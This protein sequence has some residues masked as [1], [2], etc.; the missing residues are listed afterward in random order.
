MSGSNFDSNP[1]LT[2]TL[3][4]EEDIIDV[5]IDIHPGSS[6]NAINPRSQGVIPVAILTTPD[7][8]VATVD[9]PSVQFGPAGATEVHDQHHLED[10]DGDGDLDLVLHFDTQATGIQCGDTAASLTGTTV[11]GQTIRG[12]DTIQT[13]GCR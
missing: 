3:E 1:Q 8:D 10:V 13:V 9:P 11:T 6:P 12:S 4:V 2:G 7:F 5:S